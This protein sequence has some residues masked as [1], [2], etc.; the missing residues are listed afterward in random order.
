M[1]YEIRKF[2]KEININIME[3]HPVIKEAPSNEK[4]LVLQK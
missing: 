2:V 3:K 4:A 1:K